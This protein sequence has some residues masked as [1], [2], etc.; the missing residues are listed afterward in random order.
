MNRAGKDPKAVASGVEQNIIDRLAIVAIRITNRDAHTRFVD[1]AA[2]DVDGNHVGAVH[3]G[4][5]H[6]DAIN[7]VCISCAR[8]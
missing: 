5:R 7:D 8:G 1:I 4:H 2:T 6:K 3:V